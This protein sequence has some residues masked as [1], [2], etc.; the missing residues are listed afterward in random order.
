MGSYYCLVKAICKP[1]S[2]PSKPHRAKFTSHISLL[3]I[4]DRSVQLEI[5]VFDGLVVSLQIMNNQRF[6]SEHLC[7]RLSLFFTLG[8]FDDEAV[9][10]VDVPRE[11]LN[12]AELFVTAVTLEVGCLMGDG[13]GL[14]C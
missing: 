14:R 3:P 4:V 13:Y 2:R 12:T 8:A 9:D 6:A 10:F 1:E 7:W 5:I 11:R